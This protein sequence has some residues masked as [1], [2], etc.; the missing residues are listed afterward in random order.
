MHSTKGTTPLLT[1]LMAVAALAALAALSACGGGGDD[2]ATYTLGGSASG[3]P[4]GRPLVLANNGG[5]ELSVAADGAF[6]FARPL[7]DGSAYAV[8]VKAAP[9]GAGCVVRNAAG[10]VAAAAVDTVA[11][12]CAPLATLS[13]GPW[14]QDQCQ[15]AEGGSGVRELWNVASDSSGSRPVGR[16][17]V[18]YRNEQCTGVGVAASGALSSTFWFQQERT[19][20]NAELS[21]FWG[22]RQTFPGGLLNPAV[23]T[24]VVLVRK[25]NHLCLL[26]DTSTPPA[27]PNLAGLAA[28]VN[29]AI[30][31]GR[32][33]TPR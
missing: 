3:V 9:A 24:P 5:D 8:A 7:A 27:F 4:S 21:A 11:V 31:A 14:E 25:A 10:M 18:T 20:A 6:T 19:E 22:K 32:C 23:F 33:Y 2:R 28:H 30:A 29:A 26:E 1:Q 12:R 17:T 13:D 15:P 16:G